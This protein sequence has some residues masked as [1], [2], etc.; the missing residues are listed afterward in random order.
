MTTWEDRAL[1]RADD[2]DVYFEIDRHP[3]PDDPSS[4]HVMRIYAHGTDELLETHV[5]GDPHGYVEAFR[6]AQNFT[7]E[8]RL[9][10]YG[11]EWQREQED[12]R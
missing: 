8:E 1:D 7:L 5:T 4:T 9:G 2:F 3:E 12:R 6:E 10:P 11:L